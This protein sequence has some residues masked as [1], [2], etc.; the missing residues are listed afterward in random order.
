MSAPAQAPAAEPGVS[1]ARDDGPAKALRIDKE[2]AALIPPL[3]QDELAN[4]EAS[5]V[6]E[7]CREPLAVWAGHDVLL[8]GHNRYRL[9]SKYNIPYRV[10]L[11]ELADRAAAR[12][13][14]VANQMA[15]RNLTPEGVSYL[16]GLRYLAEKQSHGGDRRAA[17]GRNVR[18]STAERLAA[19][20]R[21]SDKTVKR[22]AHFAK[23]VDALARMCGP[24]AKP[25]ILTRDARLSRGDVL[26]LARCP[27]EEQRRVFERLRVAGKR[28]R[29]LWEGGDR[30][31][32]LLLPA[33]PRAL[34]AALVEKLG[35]ADAARVAKLLAT[36]LRRDEQTEETP[37]RTRPRKPR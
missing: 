26:K 24:E 28:V 11:V 3:S 16:R 5:L 21:V 7:G 20:F 17:K 31:R 9:C 32:Q 34:A 22:D 23:A 30:P 4:L 33:R 1:A 14:V 12:A 19:E 8:D 13:W 10:R 35:R 25:W 15:R 2:L 27:E 6:A 36:L 18:L 37:N 29:P